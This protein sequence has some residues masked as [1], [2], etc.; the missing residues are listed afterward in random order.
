MN[1]TLNNSFE[2]NN[3]VQEFDEFYRKDAAKIVIVISVFLVNLISSL[4]MYAI[5]W[6][7]HF[8]ADQKRILTNKLV[9]MICWNGIIGIQTMFASDLILFVFGPFNT[10]TC[11][12][13]KMI[14]SVMKSNFLT[15][16]NA[17][18]ISKYVF[19]FWM[20]NPGSLQDDFWS[21]FLSLGTVGFS[22][23][24]NFTRFVQPHSSDLYL[25]FCSKVN[26]A[27]EKNINENKNSQVEVLVSLILHIAIRVRIQIFKHQEAKGVQP[28]SQTQAACPNNI[29]FQNVEKVTLAD[30]VTNFILVLWFGLLAFIPNK[31]SLIYL[32]ESKI[33]PNGFFLFVYLFVT[34][35]L[36][37]LVISLVYFSRHPHLRSKMW[38][39]TLQTL[40]I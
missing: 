4:L 20:K 23:T 30:F 14:K 25:S 36:T 31:L 21:L 6:Y 39:E 1:S 27:N 10:S 38:A 26:S 13:F 11:L 16:L 22:F 2:D 12:C 35:S 29:Y 5:I 24:W 9:S 7:E 8:G 32:A 37:C 15:F 40:K 18:A 3:F 33:Y 19:I 17:I 34:S 28:T